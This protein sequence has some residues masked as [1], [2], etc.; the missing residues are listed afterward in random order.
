M[1]EGAVVGIAPIR[2]APLWPSSV[3]FALVSSRIETAGRARA[4][5]SVPASVGAGD[6]A[7]R[8]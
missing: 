4:A 5:R 8:S 1:K 2:T 7:L 6:R 3:I